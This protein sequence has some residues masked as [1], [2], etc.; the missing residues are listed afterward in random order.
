M[1]SVFFVLGKILI[2][3]KKMILKTYTRN[4]KQKNARE[5]YR[6]NTTGLHKI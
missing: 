3:K 5:N 2:E 1:E 6:N 4:Q